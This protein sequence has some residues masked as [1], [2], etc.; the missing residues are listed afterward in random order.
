MRRNILF[1]FDGVILDSLPI[2]DFGFREV[3]KE[4]LKEQVEELIK[5]HQKNGGWSRFIKIRYFYEKILKRDISEKEILEYAEKF[6][7]IMRGE[8]VKKKYLISETV[9]F[10]KW[11]SEKYNLHIVSGS[12]EKEL[13]YLCKHLDIEKYFITING[14]PTKKAVLVQKILEE[15]KYSKNET[16]LIGDSINDYEASKE[17]DIDFYGFNNLGLKNHKYIDTFEVFR[18]ELEKNE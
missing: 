15:Y 13:Q 9:Q 2:K 11:A 17:N 16:I 14:S 5:F 8:L 1:D 18:K 10:L 6:S 7:Q 4:F 3:F 12:E